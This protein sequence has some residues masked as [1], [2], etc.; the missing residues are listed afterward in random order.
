[1]SKHNHKHVNELR[2]QFGL[3]HKPKTPKT[4]FIEFTE[5]EAEFENDEN[6]ADSGY[7]P[8]AR[9]SRAAIARHFS[10]GACYQVVTSKRIIDGLRRGEKYVLQPL[11]ESSDPED[12][13]VFRYLGKQGI[14][15]MF[16]E[17]CGGWS[18]TYTDAQLV[19]KELVEVAEDDVRALRKAY[20][21]ASVKF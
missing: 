11:N 16:I 2:P 20:G 1:M 4:K 14:H 19:G 3:T 15:H 6:E 9:A 17:I 18:R 13:Y 8:L 21:H 12:G 10:V 7:G 5:F